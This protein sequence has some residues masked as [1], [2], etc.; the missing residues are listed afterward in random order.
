MSTPR[1]R[2]YTLLVFT[3]AAVLVLEP[4]GTRDTSGNGRQFHFRWPTWDLHIDASSPMHAVG[5]TLA[6]IPDLLKPIPEAIGSA[7][8]GSLN[9]LGGLFSR[10]EA[11][12]ATPTRQE[13]TAMR[14]ADTEFFREPDGTMTAEIHPAPVRLRLGDGSWG[15]IDPTLVASPRSGYAW[16]NKLG[17]LTIDFAGVARAKDTVLVSV[18]DQSLSFGP[19]GAAGVAPTVTKNQ[20]TYPGVFPGVDLRY[21][22]GSNGLREELIFTRDPGVDRFRFSVG[23][24]AAVTAGSNGGLAIKSGNRTVLTSPAPFLEESEAPGKNEPALSPNVSFAV[25]GSAGDQTLDVIFDR[26]WVNASGRV[27][28]VILDPTS[29]LSPTSDTLVHKLYPTTNFDSGTNALDLRSGSYQTGAIARTFIKFPSTGFSGKTIQSATLKLYEYHS[30][31]C[32]AKRVDARQI[33]SNW[34]S[35]TVTWNSGQPSYS[36]TAADYKTVAYGYSSSCPENWLT[37]DISTLF[38]NWVSGAATNYGVAVVANSETDTNSWK[39]Y[40]SQEYGTSSQRPLLV[41]VYN[42]P[43]TASI[44][45]PATGSQ[46]NARVLDWNFSDADGNGQT[47]YEVQLDDT[48]NFSSLVQTSGQVSSASTSWTSTAALTSGTTYYWRVRV[49][50]GTDWSGWYSSNFIWVGPA[51]Y[52]SPADAAV[53]TTYMP[54]LTANT[55]TGATGG[56]QFRITDPAGAVLVTSPV[57]A[58]PSWTLPFGVITDGGSYAWEALTK[59]AAGVLSPPN[60]P[61]RTFKLDVQN[62]GMSSSFP[63]QSFSLGAGTIADVNTANGNLTVSGGQVTLPTAA[64]PFALF[65]TYNSRGAGK[66][67]YVDDAV[68]YGGTQ[69]PAWTWDTTRKWSGTQSLLVASGTGAHQSYVQDAQ[70][71]LFIPAASSI[72]TYVYLDPANPPGEVMLQFREGGTWDHRAYWG[73]N[74]IAWGTDGTVSRRS[75]GSLPAT[76]QWVRLEVPASQVGLE[77]K[78]INGVAY[79][80]YNGQ[81]WFDKTY[82]G[83]GVLGYGWT[84]GAE[85]MRSELSFTKLIER[86]DNAHIEL[87]DS[88]GDNHYY[89][90]SGQ[91]NQ[92]TSDSGDFA[93]LI[94]D[95]ANSQWKLTAPD[96]YVHYFYLTSDSKNGQLKSVTS[97]DASTL[98]DLSYTYTAEGRLSVITDRIGRRL[99]FNYDSEGRLSNVQSEFDGNR[100]LVTYTYDANDQLRSVTDALGNRTDFTYDDVTHDLLSITTPRGT[101]TGTVGDFQTTIEYQTALSGEEYRRVKAIHRPHGAADYVTSFEYTPASKTTKVTLPLG[102][103]TPADPS[104]FTKTYEYNDAAA[105]TKV[106]DALGNFSLSVFN[107]KNLLT[108]VTDKEGKTT[109]FA[110]DG[111]GNLCLET[112]PVNNLSGQPAKTQ[113]FYDEFA[114]AYT[115]ADTTKPTYNLKTR[116]IDAEGRVSTTTYVDPTNGKPWIKAQ[117]GGAGSPDAATTCF[118]YYTDSAET[119]RYGKLKTKTMPKGSSADCATLDPNY[120]VTYDYWNTETYSFPGDATLTNIPQKGWLKS[121]AQPGDT[122]VTCN[123]VQVTVCHH[124]DFRG[125]EIHA[126]VAQGDTV[127]DS[128]GVYDVLNRPQ[129]RESLAT[130]GNPDPAKYVTTG[131]DADG[132]T[133]KTTDPD[134]ASDPT[135]WTFDDLNRTASSTDAWGT[136]TTYAYDEN[137]N[138]KTK[139]TPGIGAINSLYDG[140]DRLSSLTDPQGK[141]TT[142]AVYDKESRLLE[143]RLPNAT[144]VDYAYDAVGHLLIQNNRRGATHSG[145]D[146]SIADF[147]ST[148]DGTGKRKTETRPDGTLTYTYDALGRLSQV[149]QGSSTRSYSFDL[150]SNRTQLRVNGALTKSYTYNALDRL[151]EIRDGANI[152]TDSFVYSLA[153]QV[154]THTGPGF[155]RTYLYDA[156]GLPIKETQGTSSTTWVV[157]GLSRVI[158]STSTGSSTADLRYGYDCSCDSRISESLAS[159]GTLQTSY[160]ADPSGLL[161]ARNGSTTKYQY[162]STHGDLVQTANDSG[163]LTYPSPLAYDE[164]GIPQGTKATPYGFTGGHQRE[165]SGLTGVIRMG[166]RLYDPALGRFLSKDPIEGGSFNAYDYA[167][168]DPINGFDLNGKG[169]TWHWWGIRWYVHRRETINIL[170]YGGYFSAVLWIGWFVPGLVGLARVLQIYW[171]YISG[172]MRYFIRRNRCTVWEFRWYHLMVPEFAWSWSCPP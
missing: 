116:V 155:S 109:T 77:G 94:K 79:S 54:T 13:Q 110:Y 71:V 22:V 31:S 81:A 106:T 158:R 69:V 160:V 38:R 154:K 172:M 146:T 137:S 32:T 76:G 144:H 156:D 126:L 140:L 97:P 55:V 48:S 111:N 168:Q 138:V 30:S 115:C 157:D 3:L 21:M 143:K 8:S 75:M 142:F 85:L 35:S 120:T 148:Y 124:Y 117:T 68:P 165:T 23:G 20:I 171:Y 27:W 67:P 84:P 107:S 14:T 42:T 11:K 150:N 139:N 18:G 47:K 5:S 136:T 89:Y 72:A 28:P 1:R 6:A 60:S 4:I 34:N 51:P 170:Y 112:L 134:I 103:L 65:P 129:K 2:L 98:T 19:V 29:N 128:Y 159:N 91:P 16:R 90:P 121:T 108:S 113:Y 130:T 164:F 149:V 66:L 43:P 87:V 88:T 163:T 152:L 162:F 78:T 37:F 135:A 17:P 132:N 82:L 7:V 46:S 41:V 114:G 58:S 86:T 33:T 102:N 36:G 147:S 59:D 151:T 167:N 44:A 131:Y 25:A 73:A 161:E 26:S 105:Q 80:L 24:T 83:G 45:A 12:A 53:L 141:Q 15:E 118:T 9:W 10:P 99:L 40:R 56:Y 63:I 57:V 74:S 123:G 92:Y 62:L 145:S 153:G 49:F 119:W 50:D 95:T 101:A 70:S 133:I 96:R 104:D 93:T 166:V 125:S 52:V 122:P 100:T 39:R 64:D 169:V 61:R 127:S